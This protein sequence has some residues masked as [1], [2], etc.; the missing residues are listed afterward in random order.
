MGVKSA[1]A[2]GLTSGLKPGLVLL[3][4]QTFSG[5]ATHSFGSDAS[6]IFTSVYANYKIILSNLNGE[7]AVRAFS[8]RLRANTTDF[9]GA[10]HQFQKLGASQT[11]VSASNAI[12][13]T[14]WPIGVASNG[15]G[16]VS[17]IIVE[18]QNPQAAV[19]KTYLATNSSNVSGNAF[20]Y[21]ISIPSGITSISFLLRIE[22]IFL[23]KSSSEIN[24]VSN[25]VSPFSFFLLLETP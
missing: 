14:S 1:T 11:T 24:S 2:F 23:S 17:S 6:P 18:L 19:S 8:M 7:T 5:A 20:L 3:T 21:L 22:I 16:E 10:N 9:T 15:G 4:T 12:N 13:Q 25:S